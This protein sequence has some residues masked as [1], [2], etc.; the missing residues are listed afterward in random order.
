ME[1]VEAIIKEYECFSPDLEIKTRRSFFF[2]SIPSLPYNDY[3]GYYLF[4][5]EGFS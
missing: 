4:D 1:D 5:I 3:L 2:W